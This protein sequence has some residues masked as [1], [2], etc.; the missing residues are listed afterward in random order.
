MFL[1][2]AALFLLVSGGIWAQTPSLISSPESSSGGGEDAPE[3]PAPLTCPAGGPIGAVDLRVQSPQRQEALPFR[4]INHLTEGD[5]VY[6]KPILRG[7]QKRHGEV[8]LVLVPA[9]RSKDADPLMVADPKD[10]SKPQEWKMPQTISLAA[11]VYSAEGLSKKKV[12]GFLSQDELLIAQLADYA[13][14]TSQTEALLDALSSTDS[15]SASVNAA[16]SGFASQYGLATTAIDRAAPTSAQAQALFSALNPALASYDPLTT[17]SA[18]VRVSQTASVMTAV[19]GLFFGNPVGLAAGGTAML[20]D[21]RSLAFP[22]TQFRSSFAQVM[23]NDGLNLCGPRTPAPAHTRVAYIWAVRIPNTPTPT[24]EVGDASYIPPKQKSEV[25]VSVPNPDWKYLNRARNWTLQSKDGPKIPV[26]VLKLTN[27]R[28]VEIDLSKAKLNPGDY[29]LNGYWD[30][31]PFTA[32]G[33]VHVRPLDTFGAAKLR[34]ASQDK[35]VAGTG[36]IS[37][38]LT[39]NDFEFVTKMELKRVN[40]EFAVAEPVRFILPKGLREG[41]QEHADA[42][43]DTTTL[44]A[45]QYN[46]LIQQVDGVDHPV[47]II[48]LPKASKIG[49][50]PIL[51]NRGG[52]DQHFTLKG[53]HLDLLTKLEAPGVTFELASGN[54]DATE[55]NVTVRLTSGLTAGTVLPLKAYL[56]D[57]YEPLTLPDALR[58]TGPLP[59]IASSK[60]SLPTNLAIP[61]REGEFPAGYTLSAMLDVKNIEPQ[62]LLMLGCADDENARAKLRLGEQNRTSSLSQLS[63]D[64]LF[65]SFDTSSWP[66]GCAI[67]AQ[68]NNGSGGQS[69]PYTLAH[70]VRMPQIDGLKITHAVNPNDT[71]QSSLTG[72]NLEMIEQVGWDGGLGVEVQS[73]PTPIPD[74]GQEQALQVSLPEPP[75]PQAVLHVWLRGEKLGRPTPML[76]SSGGWEPPKPKVAAAPPPSPTPPVQT[77]ADSAPASSPAA[78]AP[79]PASTQEGASAS[80]TPATAKPETAK[81]G[82]GPPAGNTPN[83]TGP[84]NATP[85][86]PPSQNTPPPAK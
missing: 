34:P 74:Q 30:W 11:F 54:S 68:I 78:P 36:K 48:V 77:P 83:A 75:N 49:N 67:Q 69:A 61:V 7:K 63:P 3:A 65:L 24:I 43:I 70:I 35:L 82:S 51:A 27:Q 50:L 21:L 85:A 18:S 42:Q 59:V 41:P 29:Y 84:A 53:E 40:D 56:K 16:V 22:G 15:S 73:L 71:Y 64:Q 13:E 38:T 76:A 80:G 26:S 5:T 2:I 45:G 86:T 12:R 37:V 81:P 66:A 6:Y 57:R 72:K 10:A 33:T 79:P 20:L 28:A 60:L 44:Q 17:P 8:S 62:S 46:L 25:P 55:R 58:I 23:P 4:T 19:A 1:R 47:P 31:T 14:K 9:K 39:G 32:V 52:A